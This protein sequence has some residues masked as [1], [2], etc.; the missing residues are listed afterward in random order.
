MKTINYSLLLI[1][2]ILHLGCRKLVEI[3][4]PQTALTADAVFSNN[5]TAIAA[6]TQLYV[7]AASSDVS[8]ASFLGLSAI[9]GLS[10]DELLDFS[11]NNSNLSNYTRNTLSSLTTSS[12]QHQFW[13]SFYGTDM[14]PGG[15]IYNSNRI[16]SGLQSQ[17]SS[18]EN[19]K[20]KLSSKVK[21]Q[22]LGEAQFIRAFTYFY[23][24]QM[25]GDIPLLTTI[26]YVANSTVGRTNK[27]LVYQQIVKDLKDAELNLASSY[28]ENDVVTMRANTLR[29]RPIKWTAKALLAR[30]YLYIGNFVDA[31]KES[32]DVINNK[33]LYELMA[34]DDTFK[35]GSRE[36]I[37]QLQP[38]NLGWNT[39]EGRI[40]IV[41]SSG[42]HSVLYPFFIN[43]ILLS[44]FESGDNRR[45]SWIG[46]KTVGT[47]TYYYPF[48]Y[49]IESFDV[50]VEEYSMVMRLAEQYLI[51]A[52]ACARLGKI[53]ESQ[54]MLN[55]VRHRAG[56][57]DTPANTQQHLL[58]AILAERRVELFTEFG[59]RWFDLKRTGKIDEVMR[60]ITP[61][62]GGGDWEPHQ[63]LYPIMQ[64]QLNLNPNVKQT[65]GY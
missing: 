15:Y 57:G 4:P 62:K 55:F 29:T 28:V 42:P 25:Y 59:H 3:S 45:S 7:D 60:I 5:E 50:P 16:I 44:A 48:K 53:S 37:W 31:E 17:Q 14:L 19:P 6:V 33:G 64:A 51:C 34:L 63:A 32:T 54:D 46:S 12:A 52:E 58:D 35:V 41:P 11:T 30:V 1:I 9:P 2:S 40:F 10:A 61:L 20:S 13:N 8:K 38:V 26:D 23:L 49:K 43:P 56:L 39:Q 24:V 65:P 36:A 47:N 18:E 21:R 27:G 22:L